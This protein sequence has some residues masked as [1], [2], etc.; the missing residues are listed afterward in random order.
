MMEGGRL[1]AEREGGQ[2]SEW[3]GP[4]AQTQRCPVNGLEP[5]ERAI[6]SLAGVQQ[7][8]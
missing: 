5:A 1:W 6:R 7:S 2:A 4:W 8:V 3:M